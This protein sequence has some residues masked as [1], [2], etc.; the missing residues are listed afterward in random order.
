MFKNWET[1]HK[2]PDFWL[3]LKYCSKK[4]CLSWGW[5]EVGEAT[6]MGSWSPL[7]PSPHV[8]SLRQVLTWIQQVS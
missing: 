6:E 2:N 5:L 7:Q 4:C 3:L 1:V 8:T